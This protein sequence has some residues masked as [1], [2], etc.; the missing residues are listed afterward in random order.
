MNEPV[1]VVV[2][3]TTG[4]WSVVGPITGVVIGWLLSYWTT[5]KQ[6][7]KEEDRW[8]MMRR[9][10]AIVECLKLHQEFEACLFEVQYGGADPVQTYAKLQGKL[11]ALLPWFYLLV[12]HAEW[13]TRTFDSLCDEIEKLRAGFKND[14]SGEDGLFLQEQCA[15]LGRVIMAAIK[16]Y[17][18]EDEEWHASSSESFSERASSFWHG[19]V[20]PIMKNLELKARAYLSKCK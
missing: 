12:R 15:E 4:W 9:D 5:K 7:K 8:R 20:F 13:N 2:H 11:R 1:Q 14:I 6:N 17:V 3:T 10:A 16:K 18:G 19:V